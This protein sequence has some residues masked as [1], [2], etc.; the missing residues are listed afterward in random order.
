MLF[1]IMR[2]VKGTNATSAA[3]FSSFE[4]VKQSVFPAR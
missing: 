1:R 2:Y 3:A 4:T